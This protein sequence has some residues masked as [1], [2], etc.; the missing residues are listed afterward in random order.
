[1]FFTWP[2]T[3]IVGLTLSCWT[4]R[5]IPLR[6]IVATGFTFDGGEVGRTAA[7]F[8]QAGSSTGSV[9]LGAN[10]SF[11]PYPFE[12]TGFP[13]GRGVTMAVSAVSLMRYPLA[14][15]FTSSTVTFPIAAIPS[16]GEFRPATATA[17]DHTSASPAIEF[18]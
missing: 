8:A 16:S 17:W 1:M 2:I 5:R 14:T 18:L 15:R 6:S 4:I 12:A 13:E 9:R 11:P 10:D 3:V 7:L